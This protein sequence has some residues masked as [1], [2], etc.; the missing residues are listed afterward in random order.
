MAVVRFEILVYNLSQK[1]LV[2]ANSFKS[3]NFRWNIS[4]AKNFVQEKKRLHKKL[5]LVIFL[6]QKEKR[7]MISCMCELSMISHLIFQK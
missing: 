3:F 2:C 4:I 6:F 1:K 7:A 5:K